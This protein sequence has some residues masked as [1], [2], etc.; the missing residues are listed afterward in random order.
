V[1]CVVPK[2][3]QRTLDICR[4]ESEKSAQVIDI[5]LSSRGDEKF[6]Y[7]GQDQRVDHAGVEQAAA[8]AGVAAVIAP[9]SEAPV[10]GSHGASPLFGVA[11][12]DS[13]ALAAAMAA[14][15]DFAVLDCSAGKAFQ[16]DFGAA[17]RC[18]RRCAENAA[19]QGDV[20]LDLGLLLASHG[21]AGMEAA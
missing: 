11:C 12:A 13:A 2:Q 14:G 9:L 3:N 1:G 8:Q 20:I 4:Y 10:P 16:H 6:I 7:P 18:Y 5:G 19:G 17:I 21:I 15:A